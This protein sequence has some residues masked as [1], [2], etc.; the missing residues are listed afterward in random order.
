M[1]NVIHE[2]I[3]LFVVI[4]VGY[5]SSRLGVLNDKTADGISNVLMKVTFPALVIASM[6][7]TYSREL[8]L[9]SVGILLISICVHLLLI[10]IAYLWSK[11]FDLPDEQMAVLRFVI[12]FGNT[13]LMGYPVVNAIYGKIGIFYASVF[14]IVTILLLFSYGIILLSHKKGGNMLKKML[15]PGLIAVLLGYVIFLT[16]LQ[17]PYV[18]LR[19]LQWIGEITIPMALL[20]IGNSLAGIS[21][22]HMLSEKQVWYVA[23]ERMLAVPIL[24]I[25]VLKG[26]NIDQ[27]LIGVSAIMTAT[28]VALMAGVFARAYGCDGG[29]GD[30]S[31]VF[32]HLFSILT[33]P[34]IIILLQL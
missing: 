20:V 22:N 3:V 7:Q 14:N 17:I 18:I 2:I 4:G 25:F 13:S 12:I 32:T 1:G 30:R 19:P 31:V 24:L 26:L 15:N 33:I 21:P 11:W 9:N 16:Q 5:V 23:I 27:Q 28:P 34:L 10:F 6:Y 29:L 8:L